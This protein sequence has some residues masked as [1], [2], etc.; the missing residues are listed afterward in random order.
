MPAMVAALVLGALVMWAGLTW[1]ERQRWNG[2]L[3]VLRAQ[4]G[5][6]VVSAERT[7]GKFVVSGL[8][9]ARAASPDELLRQTSLDPEP[10]SKADGGP[11]R[12]SNPP[13]VLADARAALQPPSTASLDLADGVLRC[14]ARPRPR[15]CSRPASGR[16]SLPASFASMRAPPSTERSGTSSSGSMRTV[17]LFDRGTSRLAPGQE[18]AIATLVAEVGQ[19][20]ALLAAA[21]R[22]AQMAIVG[23]TDSDGAPLANVPLSRARAARVHA[24]LVG[25]AVVASD[26]VGERRRQQRAGGGERIRTGQA[27]NRRVSLRVEVE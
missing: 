2:Y 14:R 1:R 8:R 27:A 17:P 4:P 3:E 6:V 16:R 11:T 20:D 24:A 19:L 9:D 5:I 12:R 23:H 15:G 22:R 18:A 7:G 21:D 25:R 26:L 10:R 13:F